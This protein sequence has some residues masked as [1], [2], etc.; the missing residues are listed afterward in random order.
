MPVIHTDDALD[1]LGRLRR[2][3]RRLIGTVA[4]GGEPYDSVDLVSTSALVVGNEAHGLEEQLRTELDHL[5]SIPMAEPAESLNVAMAATV[6]LFDAARQRRLAE[7][8]P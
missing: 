7:V 6:V 8:H 5:V 2:S 3:G 4:H 1:V